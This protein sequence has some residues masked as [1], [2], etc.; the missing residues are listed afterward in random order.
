MGLVVYNESQKIEECLLALGCQQL[1]LPWEIIV[2]DNA[3]SDDTVK[4]IEQ[5]AKDN[6]HLNLRIIRRTTNHMGAARAAVVDF[7]HYEFVA[8][9][10][11]DCIVPSNWLEGLS[12]AF[13]LRLDHDPYLAGVGSGNKV[14]E[15]LEYKYLS[16]L[17]S[18][19]LGHGGFF[20]AYRPR[21]SMLADH[22]PTCNVMYLRKHVIAAGNFSS[23]FDYTAEDLEFSQR[24]RQ[25]GFHLNYVPN[26]DVIHRL[27]AGLTSWAWKMFNYGRG[28][29][30]V[31]NCHYEHF[32]SLKV[33]PALALLFGLV[34]LYMNAVVASL[35]L[36][37]YAG[38]LFLHSLFLM[39]S[40]GGLV[41]ALP[42]TIYFMATHFCYALGEWC[43]VVQILVRALP[44]WGKFLSPVSAGER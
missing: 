8:F 4:K 39:K 24:L 25:H 36:A 20:Q 22:L 34:L 29:S 10:D 7:A 44:K 27:P 12:Q 26:I 41:S 21:E 32:L 14:P 43:G 2:V 5:F 42:L 17:L 3:S 13:K 33:A 38:A 23:Q 37:I 11:A 40:R 19:P 9:T 30:W 35:T 15:S 6:P 31:A 1:S 18:S 28:Q 16:A